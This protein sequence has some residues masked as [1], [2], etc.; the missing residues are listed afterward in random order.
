MRKKGNNKKINKYAIHPG[1][2]LDLHGLT[3][4]EA[5]EEVSAF[6]AESRN[7]GLA[8]V[9]IITGRGIHSLDGRAVLKLG[10]ETFLK[11][12]GYK[13]RE[14]KINEGGEGALEVSLF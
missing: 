7:K 6:V 11:H 10:I 8:R 1:A 3:L 4:L 14:A 12:K 9:R 5:E 13:F 2:E